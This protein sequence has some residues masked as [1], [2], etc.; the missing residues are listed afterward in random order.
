MDNDITEIFKLSH[1]VNKDSLL[2]EKNQIEKEKKH[3]FVLNEIENT[4]LFSERFFNQIFKKEKKVSVPFIEE[5]D[6]SEKVWYDIIKKRKE[7]DDVF[8]VKKE[9]Y[10]KILQGTDLKN[11][12]KNNLLSPLILFQKKQTSCKIPIMPCKTSPIK[13]EIKKRNEKVVYNNM[14]ESELDLHLA[15]IEKIDYNE[16][17][18]VEMKDFL[19]KL[20][21]KS[22]GKK[23]VLMERLKRCVSFIRN[24]EWKE[25]EN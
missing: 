15:C 18:V 22:S 23:E 14:T 13:K 20:A 2:Q 1:L 8:L 3:S 25:I 5:K 21:V 12:N 16:I 4:E 19:R 11:N 10:P 7:K 24:K 9:E 17:T 6:N